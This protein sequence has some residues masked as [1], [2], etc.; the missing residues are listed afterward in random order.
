MLIEV[1]HW[2][3]CRH[4]AALVPGGDHLAAA[5][6][7]DNGREHNCQE[8]DNSQCHRLGRPLGQRIETH[9]R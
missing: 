1:V 5:E 6:Q 7:G 9:R 4:G 3:T 2:T 8:L